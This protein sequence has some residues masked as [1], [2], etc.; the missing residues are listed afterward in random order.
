M[1]KVKEIVDSWG[2]LLSKSCIQT[3]LTLTFRKSGEKT[4]EENYNCFRADEKG[5]EGEYFR[6]WKGRKSETEAKKM[7]ETTVVNE[8]QKM[9]T[10]VVGN[11]EE[12]K[13]IDLKNN[14]IRFI[15]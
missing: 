3:S 8:S 9:G 11:T 2:L 10:F 12:K 5:G 1:G 13:K 4:L 6:E 15:G 14:W 7:D